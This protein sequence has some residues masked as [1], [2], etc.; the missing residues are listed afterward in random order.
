[1][2]GDASDADRWIALA[3]S[4]TRTLACWLQTS[5]AGTASDV[6]AAWR[7]SAREIL[8]LLQL[9]PTQ[10][11]V[12]D[13]A[14]L[15][16]EPRALEA[17]LD[18]WGWTDATRERLVVDDV[19]VDPLCHAVAAAMV[20]ADRRCDSLFAE[21]RAASFPLGTPAQPTG[22][23]P[24]DPLPR[25]TELLHA[26]RHVASLERRI[27]DCDRQVKAAESQVA[28]AR[29]LAAAAAARANSLE[30]AAAGAESAEEVARLRAQLESARGR[31]EV[32]ALQVRCMEEEA[33]FVR[34]SLDEVLAGD[35][36]FVRH[37]VVPGTCDALSLTATND[38]APHRH[39]ELEATNLL[40]D[41][42]RLIP[43]LR[44]RLVEHCGRPGLAILATGDHC[45]ALSAWEPNG[46]ED[47]RPFVLLVPE[48][49][50][51]QR[52]LQR[53]GTTDWRSVLQLAHQARRPLKHSA[54]AVGPAWHDIAAR[55]C[56]QLAELPARLRYDS[57]DVIAVEQ[58]VL[59]LVFAH[60]QFGELPI[61]TLRLRWRFEG[62]T[63]ELRWL[64][65]DDQGLP[66]AQW[67]I[68]DSGRAAESWSLPVGSSFGAASRR[69]A[70][71]ALGAAQ[72][73]LLLAIL[74]ALP[75]VARADIGSAEVPARARTRAADEARAL[76]RDA[77]K[78][79]RSLSWRRVARRWAGRAA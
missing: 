13:P 10:V 31:A 39:L 36:E 55:L 64:R 49:K 47:G 74:D 66:L 56:R 35:A 63:R 72:C 67:P 9:R 33:A 14:E 27:A 4:P 20:A 71:A 29:A 42:G 48:D 62:R 54:W 43:R 24:T 46:D 19:H 40:L 65:P 16:G 59:E 32:L 3:D 34:A 25:L 17:L 8:R 5:G 12:I 22:F 44:F 23:T 26:E 60:A 53:L 45:E 68:D 52:R 1:M 6:L 76:H 2:D 38:L 79:M 11:R 51:G 21:L 57:L 15:P 61:G 41:G 7:S 77:L 70:W 37:R 18:A 50:E 58:D 78:T 28:D 30:R 69:K 75:A 73:S